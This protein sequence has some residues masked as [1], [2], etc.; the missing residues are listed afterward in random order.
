MP[1]RRT[2]PECSQ[3]LV[4]EALR[5]PEDSWSVETFE[6]VGEF[7]QDAGEECL[8]DFAQ[9]GAPGARYQP[10]PDPLAGMGADVAAGEDRGLR[11]DSAR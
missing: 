4:V 9:E 3:V 11:T 5:D 10:R 7:I 2:L 8:Q 6:A 1:E